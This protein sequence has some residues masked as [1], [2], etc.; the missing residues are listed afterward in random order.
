MPLA[1][2]AARL[3][4]GSLG[5]PATL[6]V[7]LLVAAG[8]SGQSSP[9]R[10]RISDRLACPRP[11][12]RQVRR[13]E[14]GFEDRAAGRLT[15]ESGAVAFGDLVPDQDSELR[16]AV[17]V[18]VFSPGDWVLRLL[19]DSAVLVGERGAA[20]PVS[21]I[22]WR[23][24]SGPYARLAAGTSPVV[25]R[26]SRTGGAGELISVDLKIRLDSGDDLGRYAGNFGLV[27][28]PL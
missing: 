28:E 19:P 15:V 23:T 2:Q 26:G 4:A 8:A 22:S 11:S 3:R 21:R 1:V 17:R 5:T 12:V 20:V 14:Q 16:Q 7:L 13:V 10:S 6:V 27:L 25:A 9:A 18:R 24:R